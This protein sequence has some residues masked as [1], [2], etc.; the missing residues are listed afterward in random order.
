MARKPERDTQSSVVAEPEV[1]TR[2][3]RMFNVLLH[4]DNF[5]TMDFVVGVLVTVFHRN[6]A[7]AFRIMLQVHHEGVGVAGIYPYEVAEAKAAKVMHLAR[8]REFPLLCS[9]EEA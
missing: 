7:D 2:R 9:V 4:N 8:E 5:T 6:E 3:P 1:A